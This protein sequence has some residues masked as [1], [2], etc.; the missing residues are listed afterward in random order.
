MQV[1]ARRADQGSPAIVAAGV[2]VILGVALTLRLPL[3]AGGQIDY[4]EGVYWQSLRALAA[5]HPLF[6]SVYSSQPPA[7]LELLAPVHLLAGNSLVA[8][9]GTVLAMATVGLV[10]VYPTVALLANRG[11]ALLAMAVLAADPLSLRQS[12]TLQADGPCVYLALMALAAATAARVARDRDHLA[13]PGGTARTRRPPPS[14]LALL[15]GALLALAVLTKLLAVAA[16]P[17]VAAMLAAPGIGPT[18]ADG[19]RASHGVAWGRALRDLGAAGAGGMLTT[20]AILAPYAGAWRQLWH[21]TVSLHLGARALTVGGL[22]AGDL[23]RVL[24]LLLLGLTGLLGFVL[25]SRSAVL[26][27]PTRAPASR[28]PLLV[29]ASGSWAV[30]A[31]LPLALQRPL[32]PHHVIVLVAPLALL[33]GGLAPLLGRVP[34]RGI[35]VATL[36]MATILSSVASFAYV[37]SL[38]QPPTT[39]QATVAALQSTTSPGEPV[40]TDDQFAAALAN[41]DTP[42]ELVDTSEVRVESGDLTA[43]QVEAIIQG[44]HVRAV[45]LATDRLERLPGLQAWLQRHFPTRRRIGGSGVLYLRPTA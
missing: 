21:Q 9:R 19:R 2:L 36:G 8:G 31:A 11:A 3:L 35:V 14:S 30:A 16:L 4:D 45:L 13:H 39:R 5:G 33:A 24:P 40:V 18:S 27:E 28:A 6:T 37:R 15:A 26:L 34:A 38:Q 32:W 43:S 23:L 1:E 29:M 42:P 12:V 25:S 17:A 41:R 22:T 44:D 20:A 7:F 10:A